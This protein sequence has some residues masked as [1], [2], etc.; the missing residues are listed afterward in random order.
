ME[1]HKGKLNKIELIINRGDV[2]L[3]AY[4]IVLTALAKKW[5]RNTMSSMP[6]IGLASL[7]PLSCASNLFN[8]LQ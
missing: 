5:L 6:Y 7:N 1:N 4:I 3:I 8:I 2:N